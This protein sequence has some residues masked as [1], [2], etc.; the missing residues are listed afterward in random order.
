MVMTVRPKS[1]KSPEKP[2]EDNNE[3]VALSDI[4]YIFFRATGISL[5][6]DSSKTRYLTIG[7]ILGKTVFY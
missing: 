7:G 5:T 6:K 4:F 2:T 3:V 1:L